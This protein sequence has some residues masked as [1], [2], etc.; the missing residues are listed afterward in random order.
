MAIDVAQKII[1]GN[2][3]PKTGRAVV[4]VAGCKA[5]TAAEK[6]SSNILSNDLNKDQDIDVMY[7]KL[8][9]KFDDKTYYT[10]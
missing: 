3:Q 6:L 7:N 9:A 1:T 2:D 10:S 4:A 5:L 8:D